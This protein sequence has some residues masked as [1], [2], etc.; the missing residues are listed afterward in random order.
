MNYKWNTLTS[1]QEHKKS[2]TTIQ[3]RSSFTGSHA[4]RNKKPLPHESNI[5]LSTDQLGIIVLKINYG[6]DIQTRVALKQSLNNT[7]LT[8]RCQTLKTTYIYQWMT[9]KSVT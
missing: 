2:E 8:I 5:K 1:K 4:C 7:E 3:P 6:K 9:L